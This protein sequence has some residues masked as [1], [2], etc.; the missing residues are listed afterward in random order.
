MVEIY[1]KNK[2]IAEL[3]RIKT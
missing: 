2:V 1:Y 3:D